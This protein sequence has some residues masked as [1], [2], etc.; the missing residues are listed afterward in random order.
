MSRKIFLKMKKFILAIVFAV[1][2]LATVGAQQLSGYFANSS[3][4][5]NFWVSSTYNYPVTI[6][7]SAVNR[8]TREQQDARVTVPAYGSV[9]FGR[10]YNWAWQPGE[11]MY[12]RNTNGQV[13]FQ[14]VN[15]L[16]GNRSNPS[17]GS[18]EAERYNGRKCSKCDCSGCV[19]SNWDPFVCSK[20]G[21]KCSDHTK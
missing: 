11:I 17:F 8:Q 15:N 10:N 7:L 1:C 21:H 20:C 4:G 19:A 5:V 13:I 16:S 9:Y 14:Q 3:E 2:G 18:G 6:I 12:V